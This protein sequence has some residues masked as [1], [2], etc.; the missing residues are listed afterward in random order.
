MLAAAVA[1][2]AAAPALAHGLDANRVNVVLR[3]ARVEVVATPPAEYVS[4]ADADHDGLLTVAEVSASRPAIRDALR[5]SVRLT[6]DK[7]VAPIEVLFDVSTPAGPDPQVGADHLRLTLHADFAGAPQSVDVS[8]DFALAHPVAVNAWRAATPSGQG[9]AVDA[10]VGVVVLEP[11]VQT[12]L[13]TADGPRATLF[14]PPA[15]ALQFPA[16]QHPP[17]A[18]LTPATPLALA[19]QQRPASGGSSAQSPP[20]PSSTASL[21]FGLL[22]GLTLFAFV[23]RQ[24]RSVT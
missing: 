21:A 5:T 9:V 1:V 7:G 19:T 22:A 4:F 15:D 18:P 14:G 13:L 3:G 12:A 17:A 20:L 10:P 2:G 23:Y 24:R 8:V 6:D 11:R 16:A